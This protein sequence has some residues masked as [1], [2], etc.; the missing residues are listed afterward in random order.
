MFQITGIIKDIGQTQQIKDTFKKRE[1]VVST[2][3]QYPQHILMQ[4]VQDKC[5]MA[6]QLNIG[7]KI[8]VNFDIQ[9]RE[10]RSPQGDI[11]HF[12]SLNAWKI[13]PV[14]AQPN[15]TTPSFDQAPTPPPPPAGFSSGEEDDL[16]F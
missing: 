10:W 11:K 4:L 12:V 5:D 16:P 2:E 8:T 7:Q 1:F 13:T 9:G 15:A 14:D 3:D 6:N